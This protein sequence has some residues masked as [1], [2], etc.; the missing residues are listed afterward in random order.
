MKALNSVIENILKDSEFSENP[1]FL[2]LNEKSF[3]KDDF[4]ETQIQFYFA[5]IF[6]NRPMSALAA[7]IP[8]AK[9]R[10]EI[11]RNVWEEHGE[12]TLSNGHG[13]T[14]LYFLEKLDELSLDEVEAR[15]QWPE[16]QIFNTTLAGATTLDNYLVGVAMFGIIERMFAEISAWIGIAIVHNSWIQKEELVHYK[17]HTELDIR[18]SQDF[19]D[20]LIEPYSKNDENRYQIEQGLRL[21]ATLFNNLYLGL[22]KFRKR[23]WL[24]ID[25]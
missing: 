23:R 4:V 18:H 19:F 1:Y 7:K 9:Q 15:I 14:F 20:I 25:S 12:G 5:V 16:L 13:S 21:G 2:R 11:V 17:L 3:A 6:F 22:W 8:S 10:I 24:K